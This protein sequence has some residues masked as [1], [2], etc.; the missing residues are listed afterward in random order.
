LPISEHASLVQIM[1][2]FPFLTLDPGS[3]KQ[4]FLRLA[5]GHAF[6]LGLAAHAVGLLPV[7]VQQ[8]IVR[9]YSKGMDPHALEASLSLF[10]RRIAHNAFYLAQHEFKDLAAPADWWLLEHFGKLLA[11]EM[12]C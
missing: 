9:G 10:R 2:I 7:W 1:A 12:L 3:D 5:A 6:A 8:V 4:R 11:P